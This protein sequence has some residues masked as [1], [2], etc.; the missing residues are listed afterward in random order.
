MRVRRC[1][2][3]FIARCAYRATIENGKCL[4][5]WMGPSFGRVAGVPGKC[6]CWPAH[7]HRGVGIFGRKSLPGA[8]LAKARA[9]RVGQ[10]ARS[11]DSP[12][13]AW[14]AEEDSAGAGVARW[15]G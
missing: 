10:E 2:D 11:G 14:E 6:R 15:V 13:A 12:P 4:R 3:G 9:P 8:D 7:G 5:L 1:R